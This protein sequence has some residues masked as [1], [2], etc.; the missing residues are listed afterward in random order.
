M[1][2]WGRCST[3]FAHWVRDEAQAM[4]AKAGKPVK[5][6]FLLRDGHLPSEIFRHCFPDLADRILT[7]E[8]SRFTAR[9][10][11]FA[12]EADIADFVLPRLAG[13]E[14]KRICRQLGLMR[15]EAEKLSRNA[16]PQSFGDAVMKP[17]ITQRIITRSARA[18]DRLAAY[19]R[20]QGI[21]DGDAVMLV[22]LGYN[23]S[24][25]NAAEPVL[26]RVMGL[27]V[28]GRYLLLREM[29]VTGL[30]KAGW[31]D[32]RHCDPRLLHALSESI[33]IVEQL[34]TVAQ[35]SVTGYR[36][37]GTPVRDTIDLKGE[38]N[39]ARDRAQAAAID[40]VQAA[41]AAI[42]RPAA[43]DTP[44]SRRDMGLALLT[45]LLFLPTDSE[46]ALFA[47]FDHDANLGTGANFKLV[48]LDSATTGLRRRG[49]FYTKNAMR[50]Y[51]PGELQR[52]GLP[53]NLSMLTSRRFGLDLRKADFDV[54]QITLSA[55]IADATRQAVIDVTATPTHDGFYAVQVPIGAGQYTVCL[56]VGDRFDIVQIE[57]ASFVDA[58]QLM[59][60]AEAEHRIDANVI[61][62]GMTEIAPGLWRATGEQGI[63]AVP[64][65]GLA[66]KGAPLVLDLVFRPI[67]TPKPAAVPARKVA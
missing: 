34:C 53:I 29:A 56:P 10:A 55:I 49:V 66:P 65:P 64:P 37:D 41:D 2:C 30:D 46:V 33:A 22:D 3:A 11:S 48:D 28:A 62:D 18:A 67:A 31:F 57:H 4:E 54:G 42:V 26:R 63:I 16:T 27:D 9:A 13:R 14:W 21:A 32:V 36:D 39:A 45:R 60:K 20:A 51:L 61:V 1:T 40:F 17:A 24:V 38:Q 35:G 6:A 43:A 44:A 7:I 52:H 59:G 8:L 50:M 5:I 19:L 25:Q 47:H 12:S 23:G 58:R 15:D